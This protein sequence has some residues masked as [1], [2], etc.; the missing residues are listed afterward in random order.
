MK[1]LSQPLP[2]LALL[3]GFWCLTGLAQT[4]EPKSA[5]PVP[6]ENFF[7]NPDVL[8]AQLSPS[9]RLL[10]LTTAVGA[11][12]VSL[13]VVDLDTPGKVNR[14][15][16]FSDIDVVR[17]HWVNDQRLVFSVADLETGSGEDR[18][19]APGLFSVDAQ[20]Q[21][22]RRLVAL[23]PGRL[24]TDGARFSREA[25]PWNHVL[26]HVPQHP[27][28]TA[29]DAP[30]DADQRMDDVI[31]GELVFSS[32]R[33]LSSVVPMWLNTSTGRTRFL[34]LQAPSGALGWLFDSR[35]QAR[36]AVSQ[37]KGRRAVH[38]RGPGQTE[39]LKLSDDE[40]LSASF[41]AR[42]VDDAGNLYVTH[43][44]GPAGLSVLSR[45]DFER[46][47]PA[48]Q[49]WVTVEGFDFSGSVLAAR[50]GE[51]A[52]GVRVEA[53]AET[54]VWF[55]DKMKRFQQQADERLPGGINRV[56]CRRCGQADMVALVR[57]FSDRD[58]G[59]LWLY[60]A[61]TGQWRSVFPVLRGIN[62]QQMA[63]VDFQR[64]KARDGRDLPVWLTLPPG[65]KAGNPG[66]A[67]VLVHGGP[68]VRGGHW[69][70]NPM[71]QFL[72]SRG[73]LVISPDFRG[74]QGY[75]QAHFE[76]G[77]KQW[78]QA[79]QDDLADAVLWAQAQGLADQRVCI[80][81][82]SYGGYAT[83]MG[84]VRHP[85]LYRC[86]VAWV[87]VTDPFLMLEGSW[88]VRDDISES[89]RRYS[90]P[91]MVGDAKQD[92]DMLTRV[93]PLAQAHQ[94]RAPLLLGFGEAD[95]RVPLAHGK[96]LRE[97]MQ[98]VGREPLWVT[99]P[100]EGHSWRLPQTRTDFARRMESFLGEH[101]K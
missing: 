67:V 100:D 68:W 99:Y 37:D 93:S 47:A 50:Q 30:A 23:R 34:D 96:R 13:V 94:I 83:L 78:G 32:T 20:G 91:Q 73:Y 28:R 72:A 81:G 6:I 97:A 2:L 43:R 17:F 5:A 57:H 71:E 65:R 44:M 86:G 87:A 15:A 51:G 21:D 24:I 19:T 8:D 53:D 58:P 38:W 27:A 82:A 16:L 80:A 84:L 40:A 85:E 36:V 75:G 39:W 76:A 101:L 3:L 77:W 66:P 89:G 10:A 46:R 7:R 56:S 41:T 45:Y 33:E 18:Y 49:P 70:W 22:L 61:S 60:S 95:L 64:I 69:R 25:L 4:A 90:L 54:T 79:M 12:R 42:H 11:K 29:A 26:L 31:I 48:Q 59:H 9:G 14:V 55:D 98:K 1:P 63:A 35:G 52:A 92:A 62:R 88:W 74:S